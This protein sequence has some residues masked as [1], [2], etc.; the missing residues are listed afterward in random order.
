M[1]IND[2]D[3]EN[4][5]EKDVHRKIKEENCRKDKYLNKT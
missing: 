3:N 1:S 4:R 2:V 5:V